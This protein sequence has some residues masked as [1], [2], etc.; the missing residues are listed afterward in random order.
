MAK[1]KDAEA[2][3]FLYFLNA[4]YLKLHKTFEGLYWLS[5]M[6]DHSVDKRKNKALIARD[7]FSSNTKLLKRVVLLLESSR[8]E[9]REKLLAWKR[10]FDLNQTPRKLLSLKAKIDRLETSMQNKLAKR[11]EGYTDPKTRKF[12]KMSYLT[13]RSLIGNSPDES[14]RRACFK[15]VDALAHTNLKDYVRYVKM[16]NQYA[17]ALGF[18]DFYAY[19]IFVEEGMTKK[20][21]FTTFDQ[22]FM[23][24]KYAFKEVRN[25]EKKM[26][27]L[28]KP[29]NFG[30]ML[31]GD[32]IKEED[33][34]F[35]FN[36]ALTRWGRSFAALGVDFHGSHLN[37]DLLD[38]K[39]KWAN[40]F[41]HWPVPVNYRNGKRQ[42]GVSNFTCNVVF[43][44]PGEAFHGYNTL[45]HEGG[46]AA[47]YLNSAQTEVC[48]NTEYPPAST[49]WAEVQSMFMDTMFDSF[50]WKSRY[51]KNAKGETYSLEFLKRRLKRLHALRPLSLMSILF[52]ADFE[53]AIYSQKNLTEKKV[54][55]I[56]RA[57]H[58]KFFDRSVTALT[59]LNTPHLYTWGSVCSYHA[60]GLAELGVSQWREYFYKKYGYIVDNPN[61]GREM[62]KVWKLA[63]SKTF[64]DYVKLSTGKPL[65]AKP[66]LRDAKA[67]MR[68]VL[69]RAKQRATR[70][71]KIPEYKKSIALGA[72]ISLVSGKK[73]VTDNKKSFEDMARKYA[74]L[75]DPIR[76]KSAQG[77]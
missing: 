20:E 27:G 7:A 55:A 75:L 6:G 46:H 42:V 74:K 5:Y 53:R 44:E 30:Y 54:I 29:W 68:E 59:A 63:S 38:R 49:A 65:S 70:L 64:K 62:T 72:K 25:L 32:F 36:K 52:I 60:Y 22:V 57:K 51:A 19:K 28:R 31:A 2:I 43:G 16:L 50:E 39:G 76:E 26:P 66:W 17:K 11:K 69:M 77:D 21:L 71:K 24:T 40:G 15:A 13:M 56:A 10:Y 41:C 35:P 47:H 12:M 33:Q 45:F 8:G 34:Y 4:A 61:V 14:L 37:L 1:N 48:L 73:K 18:E 23:G 58:K 9:I 67:S 3:K